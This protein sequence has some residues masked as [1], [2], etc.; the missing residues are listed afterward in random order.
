M[1][2]LEFIKTVIYSINQ[3]SD[4]KVFDLQVASDNS[5]ELWVGGFVRQFTDLDN[6]ETF[7][8]GWAMSSIHTL[9]ERNKRENKN[10][11]NN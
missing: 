5:F 10:D 4:K 1:K 8:T 7:L 11:E 3:T 2:Q 6:L 9:N